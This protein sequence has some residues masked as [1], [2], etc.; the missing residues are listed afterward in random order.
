MTFGEM[1]LALFGFAI[2]AMCLWMVS[3]ILR[4]YGHPVAKG[5]LG[6]GLLMI[7]AGGVLINIA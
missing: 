2:F 5:A 4:G 6:A 7:A 1:S 3:A